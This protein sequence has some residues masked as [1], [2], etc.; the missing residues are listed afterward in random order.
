MPIVGGLDIHR[1]QIT[2]DVLDTESG[3]V[4]R[5]PDRPGR[6]GAPGCLAGAVRRRDDVAFALEGCTARGTSRRSW[7]G[8][9]SRACGEQADT[10]FAR[11]RKRHAKTERTDS[12]HLRELL[13]EGLGCRSLGPAVA[14]PGVRGAAGDLPRSAAEHTGQAEL[15]SVFD[16]GTPALG[17]AA[18][19]TD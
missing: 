13:A 19:R 16:Q 17:E 7:P 2:F 5:G 1:K 9:A 11:G 6:P 4:E 3:E 12:R 14:H 15:R 10:A 8:L 18:L